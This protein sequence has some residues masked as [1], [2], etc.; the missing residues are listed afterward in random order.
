MKYSCSHPAVRLRPQVVLGGTC[1]LA[2][3]CGPVRPPGTRRKAVRLRSSLRIVKLTDVTF[4]LR[5]PIPPSPL[6]SI[7]L[8]TNNDTLTGTL[9]QHKNSKFHGVLVK[10]KRYQM[11][12]MGSPFVSPDIAAGSNGKIRRTALV[13]M[14]RGV[15]EKANPPLDRPHSRRTSWFRN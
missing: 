7:Y 11:F 15:T 1:P 13:G 14:S 9:L 5:R 4:S 12:H 8:Y 3:S 2:R 6:V 10:A